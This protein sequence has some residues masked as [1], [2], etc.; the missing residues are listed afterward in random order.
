MLSDKQILKHI[1]NKSIVIYP[2]RNECL[3]SNSYDVHLSKYMATYTDEVLDAKKHNTVM[4][5]IIP[6]EGY[7]LK[8]GVLYLGTTEEYTETFN[9][10]PF[11]EGKSSTG[12]LGINIHATAG[13]GD[14]GFSGYWT[15]EI[16]CI[17]P[18]IIYPNMP[19]AQIFY[20]NID[21]DII[22]KYNDKH[23]AKYNNSDPKPTESRM[24][25]NFQH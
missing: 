1:E 21:Q 5:F 18:V 17:K 8:P 13:K 20:F 10:V 25:M 7:L 24:Y 19:I 14:I 3:G 4:Q 22:T 2:Y 9:H 15:L 12:R 16:S 6:E 11:L 23:S